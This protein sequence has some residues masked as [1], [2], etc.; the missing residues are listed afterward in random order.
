MV[1]A[2][3]RHSRKAAASVLPRLIGNASQ[4]IAANPWGHT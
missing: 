3:I 4:A 1:P 2:T